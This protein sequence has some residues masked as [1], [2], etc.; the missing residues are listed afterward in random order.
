MSDFEVRR[1]G[2]TL[3]IS[4]VIAAPRAIVWRCWT[5]TDLLK[6]W[7]CPK[8]WTVPEADFDLRPGGRMNTVMSGPEGERFENEGIFLE[9]GEGTRLTFTDAFSENFVPRETPFM[10]GYV[11]LT[12]LPDGR[13][14]LI[15]GARHANE[16]DRDKHL[17]MGFEEGWKAASGQLEELACSLA[18]AGSVVEAHPGSN[19]KVRTC[20]FFRDKGEEAAR[21]YVSMLPGSKMETVCRPDPDGPVLVA[22][23]TLAGTPYMIL[24]GNSQV[25]P[26]PLTSISVLTEDQ[27]ETDRL[28]DALLADGGEEG[29]CGWLKDRFGIHWQIVPRALPRLMHSGNPERAGRVTAALMKMKKIDIAGLEATA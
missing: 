6:Q 7:F 3:E 5:D 29:R 17:E 10:T 27:A 13:T 9:I 8:P 26:S 20:L 14:R 24:N 15:W 21:F 23:F 16:A 4:R 1:D 18:E 22:E 12:D 19:S 25:Q 11:D 2:L 28:W